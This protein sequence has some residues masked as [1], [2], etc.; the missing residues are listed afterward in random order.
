MRLTDSLAWRRFGSRHVQ[1]ARKR[2]SRLVLEPLE[3]RALLSFLAPVSYP[4]DNGP[5]AVAVGD[6]NGDGKLD[7]VTANAYSYSTGSGSVSVLLGNGDGTFQSA[8]N[9]ATPSSL[10]HSPSVAVGDFTGNGKLDI[11]ETND[12]GVSVLLG[13]GDGTFQPALTYTLPT[14]AG[15]LQT[16]LSLAVGDLNGD[17]KL[18]IVVTGTTSYYGPYAYAGTP[19]ANYVNVLLGNGEGSFSDA[20]TVQIPSGSSQAALGDFNGDGKLDVV[21]TATN[22]VAVLLNNGNGTLAPPTT[23]ATNGSTDSVVVGDFNGDGK[24]D[25]VT[26]NYSSGGGSSM[27]ILLGNG[28]GTFQPARNLASNTYPVGVGDFNRD[29][30]LDIVSENA[31][32]GLSVF[33]GNGDGSFQSPQNYD[34]GLYPSGV[35]LGDFNGDGFPDLAVAGAS[36][37]STVSVLINTGDWSVPQASSLTVNGFP[38]SITAGTAGSFI[39]TAKYAD[40]SVDDNYTGTV[41]FTSSDPQAILPADY[42]FT[43]ADAGMHTF[44]ATLT[45]AGAQSITATDTANLTSSDTGIQVNLGLSVS[46]PNAGY[47]NEPLTYTLT[48]IGDPAGTVFTD[49]INWGDGSPTQTVTGPS[50]TQVTHAYRTAGSA[51]LTITASDQGGR[52]ASWSE[53]VFTAP[54]TVAIQTDPAH[55]SQQMLI[56]TDTGGNDN[57]KLGSAANDGVS[58]DVGVQNLGAIAPTNGNPF[59]LVMVFGGYADNIDASNLATSSVLVGGSGN[60]YALIGGSARNL[61]IAGTEGYATLIAGPAGDILIGGTTSYDSNTTALAYIMA[62]WDSSDGYSTRLSKISNGG[63]LNGSYVLNTTTVFYN[64]VTDYLYGYSSASGN[65]LDWFFAHTKGKTNKD[66]IHNKTGGEV[67]TQI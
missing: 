66:E 43:A 55:T 39:V 42:T 32:A 37:T 58:L 59:A 5:A 50:G 61:L 23:F 40:G 4:V 27:S 9:Y 7:L 49:N 16:P 2:S 57:I 15:L 6:F 21:T 67:V 33:L 47:L 22:G 3:D 26:G 29:G 14:E 48:P 24:L 25:L 18:D 56:M 34:A 31:N 17:G 44:S 10:S 13:N 65:S 53:Y 38:S 54:L 8:R 51:D 45:T 36:G 62:E 28:D 35:A 63:G 41:H 46:G 19:G 64:G 12:S 52:T 30:T 1:P 11:V 60:G 20:S